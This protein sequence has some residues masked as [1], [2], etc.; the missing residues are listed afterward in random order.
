MGVSYLTET[1]DKIMYYNNSDNRFFYF[2]ADYFVKKTE[3]NFI[4]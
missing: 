2:L 1:S 4:S 3:N